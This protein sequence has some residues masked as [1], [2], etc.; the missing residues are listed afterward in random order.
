MTTKPAVMVFR[1]GGSGAKEA[2]AATTGKAAATTKPE[3]SLSTKNFVVPRL[4]VRRTIQR[5]RSS[6]TL[7][8][9]SSHRG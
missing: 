4:K 1:K 6:G 2:L 3:T 9:S 7:R 5:S 8:G